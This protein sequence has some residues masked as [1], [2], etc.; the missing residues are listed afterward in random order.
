MGYLTNKY[1]KNEN[2]K[3][4]INIIIDI[5]LILMLIFVGLMARTEFDN[6]AKFMLANVPTFCTNSTI[7]EETLEYY[8]MTQTE[9]PITGLVQIQDP[10]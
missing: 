3:I 6:G 4:W 8:N 2:K 1:V 7:Y 5:F 9:M 10:L